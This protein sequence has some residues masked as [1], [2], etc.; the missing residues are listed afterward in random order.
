MF[1]WPGP[2]S[3][4]EMGAARRPVVKILG[5]RPLPDPIAAA[6]FA[7]SHKDHS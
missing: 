4:P 1:R 6:G 7:L 5:G 3:F 2:G